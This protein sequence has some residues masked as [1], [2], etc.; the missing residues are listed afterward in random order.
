MQH[1]SFDSNIVQ[2]FGACTTTEP[3]MLVMEFMQVLAAAGA[4]SLT[5]YPGNADMH[6]CDMYSSHVCRLTNV[7]AR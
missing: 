6:L 3:A 2:F 1:V 7:L 4:S 5:R